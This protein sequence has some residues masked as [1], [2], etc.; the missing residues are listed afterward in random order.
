MPRY[1]GTRLTKHSVENA[2]IPTKGESFL[3]DSTVS[4]FGVRIY[5]SGRRVF[6]WQYRAPDTG[7]SR[8]L[9]LG[10]Y[11]ALTVD[12][13]RT[14]AAGKAGEAAKGTDPQREGVDAKATLATVFPEY[15]KERTGKL[16]A[17]SLKEYQRIWTKALAP[18][19]GKKLVVALDESAVAQWHSS[20]AATP[21]AANRAVDLLSAFCTWAERRGHRPRHS[22]P[23][24]GVERFAEA[25]KGRSLTPD[26]YQQLGVALDTA[27]TVGLRTPPPAQKRTKDAAKQ[28]HRPKNADTP[29]PADP[30]VLAALRF[31]ALSGWREQEALTLTWA[32][33][34]LQRGVAVLGDTKTGRSER[35]LGTAAL[36][37]LRSMTPVDGNPFVFPGYRKGNPLRDPKATWES[38][39][40]AAGLQADMR[41]RLHDLRHSFATV[42]RELGYGDHVI[43]RLVGHI[44]SGMTSRYGEVRE[45]TVR[46]AANAVAQTIAG[47]LDA[48]PAKILPF[49]TAARA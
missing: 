19:F 38:V 13:A 16:A 33:V 36:D 47:Y 18:T 1:I 27:K 39:K 30:V 46:L 2:P 29:R 3:W 22:N 21:Y 48:T 45:M 14:M 43:A 28:K 8:R 7:Q 31:I 26:E 25:R 40:H 9:T 44:L 24:S 49:P 32:S 6:F 5:P 11:P 20:Q 15:L 4:G 41:L 23:C 10:T 42:A 37:V 34:D 12:A 17:S 35:P